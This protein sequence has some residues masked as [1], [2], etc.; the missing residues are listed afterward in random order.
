M[1]QAMRGPE[2]DYNF[3]VKKSHDFEKVVTPWDWQIFNRLRDEDTGFAKIA[4]VTKMPLDVVISLEN[5]RSCLR[6]WNHDP[7]KVKDCL[8][9]KIDP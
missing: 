6:K 1:A 4:E 5:K 8:D 7:E 2:E 3:L 9:G